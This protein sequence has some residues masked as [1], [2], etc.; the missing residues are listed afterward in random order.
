MQTRT[1]VETAPQVGFSSTRHNLLDLKY[2]DSLLHLHPFNNLLS[3][4]SPDLCKLAYTRLI[5]AKP[6]PHQMFYSTQLGFFCTQY[7][8]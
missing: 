2:N 6:H 3:S 1:P 5:Q 4:K 8:E 7:F